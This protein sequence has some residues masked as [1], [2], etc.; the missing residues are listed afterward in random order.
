MALLRRFRRSPRPKAPRR[1]LPPPGVI[2]R[3]RRVV[4]RARATSS[5]RD[6]GGLMLE[7]YRRDTF[8]EDLLAERCN[9]LL[10]LDARLHELDEMLAAA[11]RRIPAGRCECGAPLP[12]G[13]HFCPNCGRP[14]GDSRSSPAPSAAIRCRPTRASARTAALPRRAEA[15]AEE[16]RERL[17]DR[18]PQPAEAAADGPT[19]AR[20][21]PAPPADAAPSPA[22]STASSAARASC[23]RAGWA[24]SAAPGN[25]ASGAT[26]ATGSSSLLLLLLVAAGSATAGIVAGRDTGTRVGQRHDRGDLA[27]RHRSARAAGPTEPTT[28][29]GDSPPPKPAAE[30]DGRKPNPARSPGPP[31][32][33]TR[34][35]SRR[36]PR[37]A[38]AWPMRPRRRSR[39]LARPPQGRRARLREVRQSSTPATTSSSQGSTSS[40]EEAQTAATRAL[41]RFPNAY[42]REIAR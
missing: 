1:A 31:G 14:A 41:G 27:R 10:G 42:A 5:L 7:M 19:M 13:S 21:T 18:S 6:L 26:P 2:R 17:S 32:T 34:S 40:L 30:A 11:R 12:W 39:R 16:D 8:R 22:R 37:G 25:A 20:L 29:A 33:A 24:P 9:E 38:R 15:E 35:C 28:T 3:E 36:S 23:R 4:Q